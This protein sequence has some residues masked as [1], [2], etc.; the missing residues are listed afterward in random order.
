MS[1][2]LRGKRKHKCRAGR[3]VLDRAVIEARTLIVF[4]TRAYRMDRRGGGKVGGGVSRQ[5]QGRS[6]GKQNENVNPRDPL[7]SVPKIS[8]YVH[9][10]LAPYTNDDP[11]ASLVI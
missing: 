1:L 8:R 9:L 3:A 7:S 5:Q 2:R 11:T 10:P 6:G 4:R